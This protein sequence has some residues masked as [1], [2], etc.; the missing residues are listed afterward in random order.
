MFGLKDDWELEIPER[1][2][3]LEDYEGGTARWCPGCGDLAVLTAVQRICRDEQLPP[4]KTVCVSGIGCSSRFPHY[5]KTYG[6]HGLHGRAFPV[7]CGV[8]SR[9]PDLKVFVATGD[10][11]CCSIGAGH[12][13][14]GIRYN[15]DMVVM[16][17]DNAIYGLTKNQTSP[18]S[19]QGL[20]TN[21][22]PRGAWL[23]PLNPTS[24][25][26]GFANVSF[27][28]QTVDWNPLHLYHTLKAAY[29]HKGTS[30]VRIMQRCP[31]YTEKVFAELQKDPSHLLLLTGGDN[32]ELDA[33][34]LRMFPNQQAH[35]SRDLHAA[36]RIAEQQDP[37]PIGVLFRD[38][39]RPCYEDFT[40]VGLG[41]SAADKLRGL[42]REFDKFSV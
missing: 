42:E 14:H 40:T 41:M 31:T 33:A 23:P 19:P 36:R 35:D 29:H 15:M 37:L 22:H 4:E 17:F 5:M 3:T 27:V 34:S 11:D 18:T 30:F 32:P 24:A 26:L 7:A 10:G 38:P 2:F 6:F 1:Y 39:S 12:W 8:K 21:T 13:V 25:T 16:L 9:R 28:A 20:S